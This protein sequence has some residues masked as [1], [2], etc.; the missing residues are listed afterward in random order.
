MR[1]FAW[2][3]CKN[4]CLAAAGDGVEQRR[5]STTPPPSPPPA[6]GASPGPAPRSTAERTSP[7][8]PQSLP[9]A[10]YAPHAMEV[11]PL[12]AQPRLTGGVGG[13]S[14][15]QGRPEPYSQ[16]NGVL[17]DGDAADGY[18]NAAVSYSPPPGARCFGALRRH[19][20]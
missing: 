4:R 6:F 2:L 18:S 11:D 13:R 12:P 16:S 3:T 17:D 7:G 10:S 20:C 9:P 5:F 14:F 15:Q 8:W 1:L 19:L